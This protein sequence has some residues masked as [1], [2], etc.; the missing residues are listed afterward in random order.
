[1]KALKKDSKTKKSGNRE[2]V[3]TLA[4]VIGCGVL[5]ILL[6]FAGQHYRNKNTDTADTEE[7]EKQAKLEEDGWYNLQDIYSKGLLETGFVEGLTASDYVTLCDYSDITVPEAEDPVSYISNYLVENCEVK[8]CESEIARLKELHA[9]SL[10]SEYNYAKKQADSAYEESDYTADL[11]SIWAY[12]SC[13][14]ED[15]YNERLDAFAE[16]EA[17]KFLIY[18]A[19]CEKENL[20]VSDDDILEWLSYNSL[21]KDDLDGVLYKFG[22][23]YAHYRA[24]EMT[25]TTFLQK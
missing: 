7:A 17:T 23:N 16:S 4:I 6:I 12:Y 14:S 3:L 19:I 5:A 21:T 22:S 1:M 8:T 11:S 2:L 9:Y 13:E 10:E 25:V 18:Q 15:E 20:T 24:M